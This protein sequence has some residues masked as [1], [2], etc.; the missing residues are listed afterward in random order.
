M[1]LIDEPENS[2]LLKAYIQCFRDKNNQIRDSIDHY[3]DQKDICCNGLIIQG[4][5]ITIDEDVL[6]MQD[7]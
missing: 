5:F 1:K 2:E 6:T 3:K 4:E 7:S